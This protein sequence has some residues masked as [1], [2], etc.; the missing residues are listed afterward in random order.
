MSHVPTLSIAELVRAYDAFI[1]EHSRLHTQ[2]GDGARDPQLLDRHAQ[3]G[4]AIHRFSAI[5]IGVRNP[6]DMFATGLRFGD[7]L[8][9][10]DHPASHALVVGPDLI[11]VDGETMSLEQAARSQ[12]ILGAGPASIGRWSSRL[13]TLGTLL[14]LTQLADTSPAH[15]AAV[16]FSA[17]E[18]EALPA[19]EPKKA[20]SPQP[21][22]YE[23]F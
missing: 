11:K 3:I 18:Q 8:V 4:S 20:A 5:C 10:L 23:L 21:A 22:N 9:H 16:D 19:P 14:G 15:P 1:A 2:V 13:G 17:P 12:S 6:R 7:T